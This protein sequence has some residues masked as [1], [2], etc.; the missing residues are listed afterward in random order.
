[1]FTRKDALTDI[2]QALQGQVPSGSIPPATQAQNLGNNQVTNT[3]GE[4]IN[5]GFR[6]QNK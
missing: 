6:G 3:Q 2:A 1:M 4:V 5:L